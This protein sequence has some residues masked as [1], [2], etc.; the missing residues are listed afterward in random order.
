[1]SPSYMPP[2]PIIADVYRTAL[3]W[4]NGA[5]QH[6]VNVMH[7]HAPS[8]TP[9]AV[10]AAL[11]ANVVASMWTYVSSGFVQEE[12]TVTKLD[13]S[14]AT[15][16]LATSGAKWTGG[17]AGDLIPAV[18]SIV[19]LR[20]GQRGRSHRGRLFLGPVGETLFTNGT[21]TGGATLSNTQA[22]WTAFLSAMSAAGFAIAVASYTLASFTLVSTALVEQTAA[23]QRR[24]QT[25][26][27]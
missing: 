12:L 17:N 7:I 14:T 8:S 25:R 27:R 9:S 1:M 4:T 24:R 18:S 2:L 16:Q 20:T 23:T 19:S 6:S 3:F 13:G 10:A 21:F 11:D 5:G 15:F 26:L 22:A